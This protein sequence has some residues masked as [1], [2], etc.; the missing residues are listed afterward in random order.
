MAAL[1]TP[2]RRQ[3]DK[4]KERVETHA[5]LTPTTTPSMRIAHATPRPTWAEGRNVGGL[6]LGLQDFPGCLHMEDWQGGDLGGVV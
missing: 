5:T 4:N 3:I 1:P 2:C 6:G